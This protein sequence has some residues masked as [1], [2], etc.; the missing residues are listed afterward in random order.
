MT[1]GEFL[2]YS[3]LVLIPVTISNSVTSLSFRNSSQEFDVEHSEV[4]ALTT[5]IATAQNS[6]QAFQDYVSSSPIISATSGLQ[7]SSH[8]I[9]ADETSLS[10]CREKCGK[11]ISVPCSCDLRCLVHKNCCVNMAADCPQVLAESQV[12][13]GHMLQSKVECAASGIFLIASCPNNTPGHV[14][15]SSVDPVSKFRTRTIKA[16]NAALQE[17]EEDNSLF[18][19]NAVS[20][21]FVSDISTG[22][23]Y[24]NWETY[25]CHATQSSRPIVWE[26]ECDTAKL[27][28]PGKALDDSVYTKNSP[29]MHIPPPGLNESTTGATCVPKSIG[30]CRQDIEQK[31]PDSPLKCPSYI[32]YVVHNKTYKDSVVYN[33]LHCALCNENSLNIKDFS[34]VIEFNNSRSHFSFSVIAKLSDGALKLSS[35]TASNTRHLPWKDA[36]CNITDIQIK[37]GS[38]KDIQCKSV[39]CYD[40]YELRPDGDC[41]KLFYSKVAF[42]D[43]DF[44][45]TTKEQK[46]PT[47]F[48]SMLSRQTLGY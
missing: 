43:D 30:T 23:V 22:F 48:S 4:G 27:S 3:L 10:S 33:N 7:T 11:I 40:N 46:T 26:V 2:V 9:Q 18:L 13:Y 16:M 21:A 31:Y 38:V 37:G 28:Y 44:P 8:E 12:R 24:K 14:S 20:S 41:K 15:T 39:S 42:A 25:I 6:N 36:V 47:R 1:P 29:V 45:L 35:Q 32:S 19:L 17:E 34:P 5:E